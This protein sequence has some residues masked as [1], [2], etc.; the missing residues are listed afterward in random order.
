MNGSDGQDGA[1][2]GN[3][4]QGGS[5]GNSGVKG[6]DIG[7]F[8][9]GAATDARSKSGGSY[10]DHYTLKSTSGGYNG[11]FRNSELYTFYTNYSFNSDTG[12]CSFSGRKAFYGREW[13]RYINAGGTYYIDSYSSHKGYSEARVFS[14]GNYNYPGYISY[15][16]EARPTYKSP[17]YQQVFA[18]NGGGGASVTSNGSD[19]NS[20]TGGAGANGGTTAFTGTFGSG[21]NAGNGGGGGGG[22][23]GVY[24]WCHSKYDDGTWADGQSGGAGG[25]GGTGTNGGTGCAI[26]YYS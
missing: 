5:R 11:K 7:S 21:G 15:V 26:I 23:G 18:G 9:G 10:V 13:D 14:P 17:G 6:N 4:G 22:A 1:N 3:G 19:A 25:Q 16:Y 2:G 8:T 20:T 12:I 24:A